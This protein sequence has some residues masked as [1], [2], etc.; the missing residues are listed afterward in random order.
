MYLKMK[1][2]PFGYNARHSILINQ[3]D[4]FSSLPVKHFKCPLHQNFGYNLYVPPPRNHPQPILIIEKPRKMLPFQCQIF[5]PIN[6]KRGNPAFHV[7]LFHPPL[8]DLLQLFL[9]LSRL[10]VLD[11]FLRLPIFHLFQMP[12]IF[13]YEVHLI[14][15]KLRWTLVTWVCALMSSLTRGDFI[16]VLPVP[17]L[18][19]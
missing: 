1:L 16:L 17:F 15:H 7:L 4:Q 9:R 8:A 14:I 13:P 11:E 18:T 2:I 12:V 10:F 19:V 3:E 6:M 5:R